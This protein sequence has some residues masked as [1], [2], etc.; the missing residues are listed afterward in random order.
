MKPLLNLLKANPQTLVLQLIFTLICVTAFAQNPITSNLAWE[1]DEAT[2]SQ[3]NAT[4]T[5]GA[6][7]KTYSNQYVEW[8]QRKGEMITRYEIT[9]VEGVWTNISRNGNLVFNLMRNGKLAKM[10]IEK[11]STGRFI[12]LEFTLPTGDLHRQKF[13][14]K[15]VQTQTE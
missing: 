6:Q 10:K 11:S 8:V 3:T 7:F 1:V 2:D 15:S 4:I 12:T 14:V 5:Y 13:H 9:S